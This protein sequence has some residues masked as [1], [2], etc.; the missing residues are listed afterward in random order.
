VIG[1]YNYTQLGNP[2]RLGFWE[3][4]HRFARFWPKIR[5][6]VHWDGTLPVHYLNCYSNP[7]L[8]FSDRPG[9]VR[10][11]QGDEHDWHNEHHSRDLLDLAMRGLDDDDIILLTDADEIPTYDAVMFYR[12]FT[13]VFPMYSLL[14]VLKS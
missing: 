5:H 1:E 11:K 3:S 13:G 9:F 12:H 14:P 7:Q 8:T 6:Y 10:K 2:K 4:R